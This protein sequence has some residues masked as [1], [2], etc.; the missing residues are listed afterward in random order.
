MR[1]A[2]I[3]PSPSYLS[4]FGYNKPIVSPDDSL[5]AKLNINNCNTES[6][7]NQEVLSINNTKKPE[8][9]DILGID[10]FDVIKTEEQ[11]KTEV[12]E[13]EKRILKQ[14]QKE[15]KKVIKNDKKSNFEIAQQIKKLIS[16]F[17]FKFSIN[18]LKNGFSSNFKPLLFNS[19]IDKY[20]T[21]KEDYVKV[22]KTEDK[23]IFFTDISTES[24]NKEVNTLY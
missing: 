15:L 13:S 7:K 9:Y 21:K 14:F 17:S 6:V 4:Y 5:F 8:N 16:N 2:N 23:R 22:G 18:R 20:F 19:K 10:N 1:N 11:L 24:V 3:Y 12:A